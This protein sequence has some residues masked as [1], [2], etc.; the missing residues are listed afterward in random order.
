M[1]LVPAALLGDA[2]IDSEDLRVLAGSGDD[3]AQDL[4]EEKQGWEEN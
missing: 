1:L 2:P 3:L 4:V